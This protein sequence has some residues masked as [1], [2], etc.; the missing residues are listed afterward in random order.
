M[1]RLTARGLRAV[2]A[3]RELVELAD[4]AHAACGLA[5]RTADQIA[6]GIALHR[7]RGQAASEPVVTLEH[8]GDPG[9]V[10][11]DA[12]RAGAAGNEPGGPM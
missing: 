8:A 12:L 10:L 11:V 9:R 2:P 3:N 4:V 6:L 1:Q 5:R 7:C